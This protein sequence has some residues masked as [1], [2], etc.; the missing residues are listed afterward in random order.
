MASTCSLRARPAL[1]VAVASP[2]VHTRPAGAG[3]QVRRREQPAVRAFSF[4]T[5]P[6]LVTVARAVPR[7]FSH[8]LACRICRRQ[9]VVG[10]R[11]QRGSSR[12]LVPKSFSPGS[13]I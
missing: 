9:E 13:A 7:V 12:F 8:S 6:I 1:M 3:P 5:C 4:L 2:P 10:D 11:P